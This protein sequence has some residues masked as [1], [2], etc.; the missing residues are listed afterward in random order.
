MPVRARGLGGGGASAEGGAHRPPDKIVGDASPFN[1]ELR[2]Q[3]IIDAHN[4]MATMDHYQ[5][6]GLKKGASGDEVKKAYF[7]LAKE[8]HPDIHYQEGM[9]EMKGMLE[10]VFRKITDAYDILSIDQTK[11]EYDLYSVISKHERR[12]PREEKTDVRAQ[13]QYQR[14]LDAFKKGDLKEAINSILWAIKLEPTRPAYH[15]LL[16]KILTLIP[17]RIKDAENGFIRAVELEPTNP[18]N[19]IGLGIIYK[20][21]G[22]KQ[23]AIRSFEEALVWD[24]ENRE[25]K[26]ELEGLK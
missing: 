17:G 25:A 8:Y 10:A 3:K 23:R 22:M 18:E 16:G 9:D 7:R 24:P 4:A 15:T 19:H 2:R 11:K 20:K 1:T 14:G 6:L 12:K 13:S 5:T 21:G 26:K